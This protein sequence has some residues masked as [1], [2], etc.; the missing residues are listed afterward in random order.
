[1]TNQPRMEIYNMMLPQMGPRAIPITVDHTS[2]DDVN[3][4]LS[5]LVRD[6][7]VDY[8]SGAFID[9]SENA[10][11][12]ILE[13]DGGTGQ[14]VK[15]PANSQAYLPVLSVNPPKFISRTTATGGLYIPII[16]YNVP[17]LPYVWSTP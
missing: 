17:M 6:G 10:A 11:E 5:A 8:V 15:V 3:I 9:N 4:D 12:L 1:M 7:V 14:Q 16:F 2:D 13:V